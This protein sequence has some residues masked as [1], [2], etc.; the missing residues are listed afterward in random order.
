M[1]KTDDGILDSAVF[2]GGDRRT[3]VGACKMGVVSGCLVATIVLLCMIERLAQWHDRMDGLVPILYRGRHR[4]G[5][6]SAA[7][8]QLPANTAFCLQ[9]ASFSL[10]GH[11]LC[12]AGCLRVPWQL[13]SSGEPLRLGELCNHLPWDLWRAYGSLWACAQEAWHRV[14]G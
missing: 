5:Y 11:V 4:R 8:V 9:Y 1:T 3:F 14:Q 12:G 7:M 6:L 13:A 2:S 10:W